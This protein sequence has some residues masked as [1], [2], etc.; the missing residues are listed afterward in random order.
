MHPVF[1]TG[2]YQGRDETVVAI[3]KALERAGI[4][5]TFGAKMGIKFVT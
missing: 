1:E 4:E 3:R 2:R 5:F